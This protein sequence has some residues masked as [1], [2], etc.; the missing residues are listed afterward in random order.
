MKIPNNKSLYLE[1]LIEDE[2]LSFINGSKYVSNVV[3]K[4]KKIIYIIYKRS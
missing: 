3:K 2:D 1:K 4:F